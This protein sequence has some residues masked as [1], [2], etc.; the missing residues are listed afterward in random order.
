MADPPPTAPAPRP[1]AVNV[2]CWLLVAGAVLLTAGGL[3]AALMSFDALRQAVPATVA[4]DSLAAYARLYRGTGALF[5]IAGLA[6]AWLAARARNRDRRSRRAAV[7]LALAVVVLVAVVA[8]L[9]GAHVL[10]LLGMLAIAVGA[11][12]LT[13]PAAARWYAGV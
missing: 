10:A 3:L 2:A 11:L 9:V 4:D 1:G 13:R 12:L 8:V 6:L 7:A 5:A